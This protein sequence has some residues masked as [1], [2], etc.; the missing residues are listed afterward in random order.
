MMALICVV[1]FLLFFGSLGFIT[2][3]G[4]E[5]KVPKVAGKTAQQAEKILKDLGFEVRIDS[6]YEPEKPK[7]AVLIQ[8]PEE[9]AIVKT[10]RT[11]FLTVNKVMPPNTAMPKLVDLTLRSAELLLQSNRLI[12]GDTILRPDI[13]KGLVLEQLING[14]PV[15]PGT[16]IP[17][18]S[19]IT[20]VVGDGLGN[21]EMDVPDVMGQPYTFALAD[22]NSRNLIVT[23]IADEGSTDTANWIV[24]RQTP[25]PMTPLGVAG[26]IREGDAI[27]IYVG[28]NPSDSTIN[29][30]RNRWREAQ[31]VGVDSSSY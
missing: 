7:L 18:G 19:V 16:M 3:H 24:Y 22:L 15:P 29:Y 14:K 13:G 12:L 20:L 4:E 9:G 30:Y 11:I 2:N 5:T 8:M 1:V 17:Q 10:G 31:Q 21:T 28:E 27:D 23:T 25:E 6:T 26:R